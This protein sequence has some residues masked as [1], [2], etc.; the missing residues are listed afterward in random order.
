MLAGV[1]LSFGPLLGLGL[2]PE[3][4]TNW[5]CLS[6]LSTDL[7]RS[8]WI[9]PSPRSSPPS[10]PFLL[11]S[12]SFFFPPF[13]LLA[14][15]TCCPVEWCR[16]TEAQHYISNLVS[17]PRH[18]PRVVSVWTPGAYT[19][20]YLRWNELLWVECLCLNLVMLAEVKLQLLHFS[21]LQT[22][23]HFGRHPNINWRS[24]SV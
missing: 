2:F 15:L 20:L 1:Y 11:R 6:F 17:R 13:S 7:L 24:Y 18:R 12:I 21:L 23:S 22:P 3:L 8:S 10:F 19:S 5:N 16:P 14:F 9:E 4:F